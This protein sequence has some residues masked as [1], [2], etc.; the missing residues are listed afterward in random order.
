MYCCV[1][2]SQEKRQIQSLAVKT[3]TEIL[4]IVV[5]PIREAVG[6]DVR[7]KMVAKKEPIDRHRYEIMNKMPLRTA[8]Q[9]PRALLIWLFTEL[10][11]PV[12]R[13]NYQL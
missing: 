4:T 1:G 13:P 5:A 12:V 6:H 7:M 2:E 3:H 11:Q 9:G 8:S 10:S